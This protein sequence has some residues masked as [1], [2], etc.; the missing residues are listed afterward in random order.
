MNPG[1]CD[2]DHDQNPRET[3]L[4]PAFV[5]MHKLSWCDIGRSEKFESATTPLNLEFYLGRL[6]RKLMTLFG[7]DGPA[8]TAKGP[9]RLDRSSDFKKGDRAA[10]ATL[11]M[12]VEDCSIDSM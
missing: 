3:W 11:W 5:S 2:D 7:S 8:L 9:V 1:L 10:R 4:L 12:V 6:K